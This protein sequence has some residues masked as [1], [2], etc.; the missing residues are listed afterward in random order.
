MTEPTPTDPADDQ[1]PPPPVE[2]Q[3]AELAET[4]EAL[5]QKLDVPTRVK[6]AAADTAHTAQVKAIENQQPL[7]AFGAAGVV[8]IIAIV[9]LRRRRRSKGKI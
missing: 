8:A 7:A 5:A 9:L 4:V 1:T 2:Q 6:S 3:R